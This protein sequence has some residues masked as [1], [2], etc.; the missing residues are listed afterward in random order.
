VAIVQLRM[1]AMTDRER[2]ETAVRVREATRRAGLLLVINDRADLARMVGADGLHVG[3]DDLP[4]AAARAVAGPEVLLGVSTHSAGQLRDALQGRPDY[5]AV[6][7]VFPTR[8]KANPDPVVG[9]DLVRRARAATSLPLV[10]IGG[11]TRANARAVVKAGADGLAVIA[12]L[13]E[14][15]DLRRAAA[16]YRRILAGE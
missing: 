2:H 12:D 15:D 14:A 11:V 16:E 5:V 10:A 8:T 13:L 1:K 3:Q 9:L 4:P 6:G 7:P